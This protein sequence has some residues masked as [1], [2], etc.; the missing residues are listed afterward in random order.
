MLGVAIA[1]SRYLSRV[2]DPL[3]FFLFSIPKSI[4]LPM[5]ILY[6][7]SRRSRKS[8]LPSAATRILRSA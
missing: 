5:F 8:P 3:L 6:P 7:D 4:F 1:E 2:F